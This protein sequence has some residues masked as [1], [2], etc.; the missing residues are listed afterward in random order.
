MAKLA[1][2]VLSCR[3]LLASRAFYEACGLLFEE[4]QHAQGPVHFSTMVSGV[5]LE[6]YPTNVKY[7]PMMDARRL[8]IAV[9]D[10]QAIVDRLI[11]CGA[12][13]PVGASADPLNRCFLDPDGRT[14]EMMEEEDD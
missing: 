2:I 1:Y 14:I 13:R 12:L 8:G 10:V 9:R 3:D 4:E 5:V 11:A 7:T 6:L